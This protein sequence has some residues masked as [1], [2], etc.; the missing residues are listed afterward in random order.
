MSASKRRSML[1]RRRERPSSIRWWRNPSILPHFGGHPHWRENA[2]GVDHREE[3]LSPASVLAL[4]DAIARGEERLQADGD[5]QAL[6]TGKL[7][8]RTSSGFCLVLFV[9]C[10]S[11]GGFERI[12]AS[13]GRSISGKALDELDL[14]IDEVFERNRD[15]AWLGFG[16]GGYHDHRCPDCGAS[17]LRDAGSRP[18]C[19]GAECLERRSPRCPSRL[20]IGSGAPTSQR[21]SSPS[22]PA[23]KP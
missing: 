17:L 13:N 1:G 5:P 12:D 7:S 22:S 11:Y 2:P 14:P 9:D 23:T 16:L 18:R 15:L 21:S 3:P 20:R 10:N 6:F 19:G 8:Y 4:L